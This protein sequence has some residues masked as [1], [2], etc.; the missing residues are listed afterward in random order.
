MG[1][2]KRHLKHRVQKK[3]IS[4]IVNSTIEQEC[5]VINFYTYV[6]FLLLQH[7]HQTAST[8][9]AKVYAVF[10]NGAHLLN[11]QEDNQPIIH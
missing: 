2:G 8:L 1:T 4:Y 6:K 3:E 10:H 5:L 11:T 9:N 7:S